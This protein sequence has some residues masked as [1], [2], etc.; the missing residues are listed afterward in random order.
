MSSSK[1]L[2]VLRVVATPLGNLDDLSPRARAALETADCIAAEDTRRTGVLLSLLGIP[3]RP[4]LS[5]FAGREERSITE[6]LRRLEAGQTVVL[7]TDGGTPGV[8]DPGGRLL[9]AVYERGFRVEPIPGP[10]A[11]A[12]AISASSMSGGSF[13]FEGFLPATSAKRRRRLEELSQDPRP[14]I[15]FEAPHRI[16][17]FFED[18]V[19]VIGTERRVTLVREGTKL[20]EEVLEAPS[21][22]ILTGLPEIAR[23]EYTL[24]VEGCRKT[25]DAVRVDPVALVRFA[26]SFGLSRESAARRVA[27]EFSLSRSRLL[28]SATESATEDDSKERRTL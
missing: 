15:F 3:K 28:R 19:A 16:R 27:Q 5:H 23:G 17:E 14:L 8:S 7:A 6:I 22:E 2:G 13:V 4:M 12:M 24:V 25:S 21:G 18:L 26:E 20:H 1:T 11:V 9:R 10:S